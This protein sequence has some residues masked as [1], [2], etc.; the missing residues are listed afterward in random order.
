MM[1]TVAD[2]IYALLLRLVTTAQ[3][4]GFYFHHE[5]GRM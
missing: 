5:E 2:L 4:K 3:L 1:S